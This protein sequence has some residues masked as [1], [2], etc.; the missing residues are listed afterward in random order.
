MVGSPSALDPYYDDTHTSALVNGA[1][2]ADNV[3]FTITGETLRLIP[4]ANYEA[5]NI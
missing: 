3:S 2:A 5:K 4:S 1:R